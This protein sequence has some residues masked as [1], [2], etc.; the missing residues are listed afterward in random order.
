MIRKISLLILFIGLFSPAFSQEKPAKKTSARPDIPGSFMIEYGFNFAP[1]ATNNFDPNFIGSTTFNLYYQYEFRILKSHFSF[2]PGIGFSFERY[3]F[4]NG[5]VLHNYPGTDSVKMLSP[6]A[7]G[8]PKLKKSKLITNYIEVPLELRYSLNPDDPAR[9][10]KISVGGRIGYLFDSFEKVKYSEDSQNKKI[11]DK[12]NFN[13][14]Q[15]RYGL[16]SRFSFGSF[17]LFGYYNLNPLFEKGKGPV[18]NGERTEF[19]TFTVGLSLA[20]F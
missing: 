13:L 15:F 12:Q 17:S 3:K 9:S 10:F 11:K 16:T 5:H 7:A 2:V 14:S 20:S 1:V 19:S 4:K 18:L 8:Y 6:I